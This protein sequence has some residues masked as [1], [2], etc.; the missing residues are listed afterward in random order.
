MIVG[1]FVFPETMVGMIDASITFRP[2]IPITDPW[3]SAST[4]HGTEEI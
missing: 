2:V 3:E 4:V 1:A